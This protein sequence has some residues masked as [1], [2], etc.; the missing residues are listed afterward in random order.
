MKD[1]IIV[2]SI[3]EISD[4][5]LDWSPVRSIYTHQQRFEQTLETIESIRKH[6]PDTDIILAECSPDSE[7]MKELEKKVDIF[8]NTYPNDLIRDGYNKSVCEAQ[9]MLYVF[10]RVDFSLYQNIFKMTGR[11]KLTDKFNRSLWMNNQATC[12]TSDWYSSNI[13]PVPT[14]HTFFYKITNNELP[15]LKYVFHRMINHNVKDSM[16]IT[17]YHNLKEHLTTI[18]EIGI[19]VRWSCHDCRPHA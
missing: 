18:H 19:E 8:I 2:T 11:Y 15:I 5:P 1:C 7:Y 6:L 3:V 10:D 16:E 13:N 17:L 9:L 4:K 14:M 12:C